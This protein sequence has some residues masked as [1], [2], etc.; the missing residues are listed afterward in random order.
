MCCKKSVSFCHTSVHIYIYIYIYNIYIYIY[1]Y[2]M[3]IYTQQTFPR[4][5]NIVRRLIWRRDVSQRQINVEITFCTSTLEFTTLNNF[6]STLS[7]STLLWTTL[8]NVEATLSFSTSIHATLNHVET[9][10]WIW[11]LKKWK[12]KFESRT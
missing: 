1:M 11:P 7:I 6:E 5:F 2:N 3:Y 8:G 10:L 4:C 9:K 12:I